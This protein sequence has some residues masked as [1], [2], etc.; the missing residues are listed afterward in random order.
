MKKLICLL[1]TVV[2]LTSLCACGAKQPEAKP[3][4]DGEGNPS[5]TIDTPEASILVS[6][7]TEGLGNIAYA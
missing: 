7:N 3:A 4:D 1:L 6:I 5:S 2:M